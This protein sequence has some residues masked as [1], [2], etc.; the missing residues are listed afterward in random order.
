MYNTGICYH[1]SVRTLATLSLSVAVRRAT[2]VPMAAFSD[3]VTDWLPREN[4]G[5]DRSL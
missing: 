2:E 1:R 3:T 4:C 5:V